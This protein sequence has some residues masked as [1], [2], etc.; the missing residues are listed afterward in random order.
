VYIVVVVPENALIEQK[1]GKIINY[2]GFFYSCMWCDIVLLLS[3]AA[4]MGCQ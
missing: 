4:C 3:F 1:V 2:L